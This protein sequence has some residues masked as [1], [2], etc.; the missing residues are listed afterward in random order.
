MDNFV[1]KVSVMG[2]AENLSLQ[3]LCELHFQQY[4]SPTHNHKPFV[5]YF[6]GKLGHPIMLL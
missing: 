4:G 3:K 6:R 1:Y 5:Y 2:T